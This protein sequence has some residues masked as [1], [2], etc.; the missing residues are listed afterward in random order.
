MYSLWIAVFLLFVFYTA[1][2]TNFNTFLDAV[3][4]KT[5]DLRQSIIV[6]SDYKKA[7]KNIVIVAIDDASYEYILDKYGEWPLPRDIY[8]KLIDYIEAQHPKTIA[9]DLMFV[10]SIKDSVGG[11]LNAENMVEL[12]VNQITLLAYDILHEEVMDGGFVQL[13]HNGYGGFIFQNPFAKVLKLWGLRD[14]SK[15][16]YSGRALYFEHKDELEKDCTD[17]EFMALFERFPA[18]DDLDDD[19]VE[20]EEEW[21]EQIAMYVDEHIN[22]FAK[23]ER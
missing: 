19:F 16:V 22:D 3:E 14:L 5:F 15:L 18:F 10:K 6:K 4:N 9:F 21:T 20:H 12:N 17:E 23:I 11:E 13:I 8:A 7:N 1:K 2:S